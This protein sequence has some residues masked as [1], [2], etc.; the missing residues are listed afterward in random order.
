MQLPQ[1]I[2][3]LRLGDVVSVDK[4]LL[5]PQPLHVLAQYA[6]VASRHTGGLDLAALHPEFHKPAT[7]HKRPHERHREHRV[8]VAHMPLFVERAH[9]RRHLVFVNVRRGRREI[10]TEARGLR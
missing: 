3:Q 7:V 4:R 10:H 1:L 9:Q 5:S 6:Y 8:G 2:L